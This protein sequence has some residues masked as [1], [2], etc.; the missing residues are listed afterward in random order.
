[1]Y[2]FYKLMCQIQKEYGAQGVHS[3][4]KLNTM[5]EKKKS[6]FSKLHHQNG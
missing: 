5:C 6:T 3:I 1:M 4:V 2:N